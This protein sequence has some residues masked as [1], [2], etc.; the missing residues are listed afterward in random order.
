MDIQMDRHIARQVARHI[1]RQIDRQ[2]ARHFW[3]IISNEHF[4]DLENYE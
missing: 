3:N 4:W 2:I 1:A